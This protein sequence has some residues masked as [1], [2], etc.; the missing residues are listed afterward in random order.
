M[1][2]SSAFA[3]FVD[4]RDAGLA[5]FWVATH[6]DLQPFR[7]MP[8]FLCVKGIIFFSFWQGFMV[9]VLVKLG[10]V[11]SRTSLAEFSAQVAHARTQIAIRRSCSRSQSKVRISASPRSS[12][13]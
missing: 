1:I 10:W 7:P 4:L 12:F 9:S 6:N 8:K 11:K 5:M 3:D 2:T 13:R